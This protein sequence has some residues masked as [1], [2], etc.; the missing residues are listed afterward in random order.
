MPHVSFHWLRVVE[1]KGRGCSENDAARAALIALGPSTRHGTF[2]VAVHFGVMG[3][4]IE[5]GLIEK[6]LRR[7]KGSRWSGA[8]S[9]SQRV[10]RILVAS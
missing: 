6:G 1:D 7:S 3:G 5:I 10:V 4:D 9:E 2:E 8:G